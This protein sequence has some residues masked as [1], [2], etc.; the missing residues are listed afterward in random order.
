MPPESLRSLWQRWDDLCTQCGACCYQRDRSG[1]QLII[2]EQSPC[3]FLDIQSQLCTVYDTRLQ[4][5]AECK[6][7]TIFHALF[8]RYLPDDCGYV[9]RFRKWRRL[10]TGSLL[11]QR[12]TAGMPSTR[13]ERRERR[14]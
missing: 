8:S 4:T 6:R 10:S 1:G 13:G 14:R 9:E 12:R 11:G 5:C 7:V 3:R 2:H